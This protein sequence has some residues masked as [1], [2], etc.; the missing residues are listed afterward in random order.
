[1]ADKASRRGAIDVGVVLM[2]LAFAT[3]GGF[4]FWL[5]GQAAAE[6]EV[7]IVEDSVPVD[8]FAS[9]TN[10]SGADIQMNA[11]PFEG[12]LIRLADFAVPGTLGT[13]GF[14]LEMPNGNPF[15]VSM[16]A[17][18]MAEGLAVGSG[19]T[20]TVTGTVYAMNDSTLVAWTDTGTIQ[21]GD[22]IVAEFATHYVE[23]VQVVVTGGGGGADGN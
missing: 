1:M 7:T 4:I 13:Q 15:L 8:E 16:S 17:E 22:R 6:R 11:T 20:V 5:T 21:Q 9:A 3:M 23:A 10:L 2:V 18:V 12:R 19:S 14:W